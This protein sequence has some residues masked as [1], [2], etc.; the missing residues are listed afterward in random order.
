MIIL[1]LGS[2][3]P[4][5]WGN[6]MQTLDFA[7]AQL[8]KYRITIIKKSSFYC[9]AP[10]TLTYK[11]SLNTQ[12]ADD[13]QLPD[14]YYINVTLMVQTSKGAAPLLYCLKQIERAAGRVAG[15][16]WASRPLDID[17]IDYKGVICGH[18]VEY[19]QRIHAGFLPLTLP[20]PGLT[21]RAFVLEPLEQIAPFWHHPQN[22][23]TAHQLINALK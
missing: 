9:S 12:L 11:N 6:R 4:S 18:G 22:G 13:D 14:Q 21:K 15:K 16:R 17:I 20:H 5:K 8:R 3:L 2:N 10:M 19:N 7:M 1:S 23:K